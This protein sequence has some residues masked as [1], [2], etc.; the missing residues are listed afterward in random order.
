MAGTVGL[1]GL[2]NMCGPMALNLVKAGF[3]LVVCDG[4]RNQSRVTGY[5]LCKLTVRAAGSL[6]S[7]A[8]DRHTNRHTFSGLVS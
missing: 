5:C 2:G 4:G 1:I 6:G 3:E 8:R 7:I